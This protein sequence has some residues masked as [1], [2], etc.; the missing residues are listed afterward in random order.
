[1]FPGPTLEFL[2]NPGSP[3]CGQVDRLYLFVRSALYPDSK[4]RQVHS[5]EEDVARLL[6]EALQERAPRIEV[7][8]R[9]WVT[10]APPTDH[11][12]IFLFLTQQLAYVRRNN[13]KAQIVV[14]LS[15]GTPAMQTMMLLALQ[16]RFAGE[17]VRAFQ[18][19]PRDKRTSP[20]DVAREV[21]WNLLGELAGAPSD[22]E[23][24]A[25]P[26]E[27]TLDRAKSAPM[28]EVARL[29]SQ[30]GSVPFPV[31]IIGARGTGK[32]DVAR[33]L[34]AAFR[35]W[36]M[37]PVSPWNFHLNCAEFRGDAVMM[38]DA[39]FGHIKGAHSTASQDEP[40]LLETAAEDCVFLDEIHWMHPQ[41]QGLLLVALQRGGRFR[42]IGGSTDVAANFRLLAAT[43]QTRA[44]LGEKL[45]PDFLDRISDLVL[46]IPQLCDCREDLGSI[47]KSVVWRACDEL[48]RGDQT[49]AIDESPRG[50]VGR[51]AAEFDPHEAR[52]LSE[53]SEM[54][55]PGN[56]RDLEKL[57]RRLL[58]AALEGQ[59]FASIKSAL[60]DRELRRSRAEQ[61]A[62]SERGNGSGVTLIDELPTQARCEEYLREVRDTGSV[63][64]VSHAIETWERRLLFAARAVTGSGAQASRL[65]GIK[66]RNFNLKM[67]KWEGAAPSDTRDTS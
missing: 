17:N 46:E 52:I 32:T 47:W 41:A 5:K 13:T 36:T 43:N 57:A 51:L 38:R 1:M 21:P 61:R 34:R 19:V 42:R 37:R 3:V 4:P 45:T 30:Y 25:S 28:R 48:V 40:G 26:S 27:W 6:R 54:Q 64:D 2:C 24:S 33:R 66:P 29:V 11:R 56:F 67:E 44:T 22:D 35:I 23:E 49:R 31:L 7:I 9:G 50:R 55:L 62:V 39:L 12:A 58:V 16:A 20:D 8:M 59:R 15:P 60:V 18:G 65:V 63:M 14:N 53:L 10:D